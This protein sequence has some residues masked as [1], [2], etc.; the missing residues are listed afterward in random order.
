MGKTIVIAALCLG[1]LAGALVYAQQAD[2]NWTVNG[3]EGN[4]RYSP[5][6]QINRSNVRDLQVAWT[7]D[8]QDAFKDSEMQSNPIVVDGVLFATT[9]TM[10]VVAVN[11]ETGR[12]IWKFDPSG[13]AKP[14]SRF[15]HRGVTV[16]AD[17]VFVS[18][19]NFLWALD[20]TTGQPIASFGTD[21]RIDLREGL[22]RPPAGLSVSASTPG[23]VFED[24]LIMPSSVPETL[25]GTPGHIRAFDV[26]TGKQRWIFHTIPQPGELGYDTWPKD[27]Y[28]ITGGANAWAGVTVDPKLAMVF[29]ATGSASFDFYGVTRHGDN[30][31]ANCV[32]ALDAR[33]G[34]RI[35][36]FQ[37]IKHDLWDWDFPAPPSLVTVRR[38]GKP[39]DAVAQTTKFGDVFVLDRRTGTPLFPIEYREA[40]RSQVDGERT[41]PTQPRPTRPPP[42]ARQGLTEAMLTTRTPEAHAA[43]LERFRKLKSG[44]LTP[45][46]FEGTIVFPGFD[47]GAEWG[48]SAFDPETGLLYVNSNEMAW[49]VKIIP[50]NDTSLYNANCATC[51]REDRKGSPMAPSLVDIGKRM[52]RDEIATIVRQG[53]GRMP[54]FPDMGARNINDVAEFLVTGIDKGADP[55][56]KSDP[57]WLKYRNDG[58]TIFPGPRRLP[59]DHAAVGHA[60]CDRSQ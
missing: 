46:S 1:A 13:G 45:P 37:G 19:R 59:G 17:R 44:F 12:E 52:S 23:V 28:K 49:I 20:K 30:L 50:N 2:V 60:Q 5:L 53:T 54:A 38:N 48:G 58:Y 3:G 55:K 26:K 7:Y 24:L 6:T 8:S 31:F 9:P 15:R 29:A 11:A 39:V 35:W 27:A 21:G 25:P 51:H 10:K 22:G 42:F 41:A 14:G 33:T 57:N 36:H 34:K 47:G 32:L 43:V 4:I 56:L 40:P 16:H 18:Y